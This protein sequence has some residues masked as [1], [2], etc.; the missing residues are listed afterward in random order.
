LLKYTTIDNDKIRVTVETTRPYLYLDT[1]MWKHLALDTRLRLRFIDTANSVQAT[2]MYSAVTFLELARI[3]DSSQ[4]TAISEVMNNVDYG[5]TE[6]VYKIVLERESEIQRAGGT[7]TRH[8]NPYY[9]A[10]LAVYLAKVVNPLTR[11][12]ISCILENLKREG[13]RDT[14]NEMIKPWEIELTH[15]VGKWRNN[16]AGLR[17]AKTFLK[18]K[19]VIRSSF[20]YTQ[21]I[22]KYVI[23]F[24]VANESMSM[25]SKEWADVFH[26]IIP[27]AYF[28]YVLL[29]GRW[30]K[31]I[32]NDLPIDPPDI[33]TVF[34]QN[35]IED[36]FLSLA[37]FQI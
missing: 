12:N 15:K 7:I 37:S 32:R 17:K 25:P 34:N 10:T 16:P 26:L 5:L 30:C 23:C 35:D 29:D 19:K 8:H 14:L 21:D 36:F 31:F 20:P 3:D 6:N 27:V 11:N 4:I 2:I 1:W 33:A 18:S 28:D 13:N 24:I 22:V 9:D